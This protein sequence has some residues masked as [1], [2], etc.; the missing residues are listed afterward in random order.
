LNLTG[1]FFQPLPTHADTQPS[2]FNGLIIEHGCCM[3]QLL[4]GMALNLIG[5]CMPNYAT[6]SVSEQK[7]ITGDRI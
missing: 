2:V 1:G 5:L 7:Y 4:Q 6:N 3:H